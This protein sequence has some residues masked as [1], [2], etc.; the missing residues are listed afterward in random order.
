MQAIHS[1]LV[2]MDKI[3]RCQA[4]KSCIYRKEAESVSS[5]G[6]CLFTPKSIAILT[7]VNSKLA[8]G[9]KPGLG[10]RQA[11]HSCKQYDQMP[12]KSKHKERVVFNKRKYTYSSEWNFTPIAQRVCQLTTKGEIVHPRQSMLYNS[13]GVQTDQEHSKFVWKELQSKA[14]LTM[15]KERR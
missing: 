15:A 1:V 10:H 13:F 12:Q 7:D 5:S 2:K 3:H 4:R 6:T 11:I 8:L 14:D 9:T